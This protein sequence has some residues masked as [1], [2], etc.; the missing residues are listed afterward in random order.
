MGEICT[1]FKLLISLDEEHSAR[2]SGR[3]E[4]Y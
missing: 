1:R 3:H 4:G 2:F